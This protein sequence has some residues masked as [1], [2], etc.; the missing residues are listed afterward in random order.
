MTTDDVE[1][2][3]A[4]TEAFKERFGHYPPPELGNCA[5]YEGQIEQFRRWKLAC[6]AADR[7]LDWRD[8]IT[9]PQPDP[10][11]RSEHAIL[12]R[13]LFR[14]FPHYIYHWHSV[15]KFF[16]NHFC[17]RAYDDW[18]RACVEQ[19]KD[20]DPGLFLREPSPEIRRE[21]EHWAA[22]R[23]ARTEQAGGDAPRSG[24][25]LSLEEFRRRSALALGGSPDGAEVGRRKP[26]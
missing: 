16:C 11:D 12:T 21:M 14:L 5:F 8:F 26:N 22:V 13:E 18:L 3:R 20:L 17:S 25:P 9:L 6:L 23:R 2:A 7:E 19:Q 24:P 4:I 1:L 10:S 15:T